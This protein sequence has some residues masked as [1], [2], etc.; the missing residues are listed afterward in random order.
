MSNALELHKHY[1]YH[2]QFY[3][4]HFFRKQVATVQSNCIIFF[5]ECFEAPCFCE[6]I[7]VHIFWQFWYTTFFCMRLLFVETF[8][9]CV[10]DHSEEA[11]TVI[12]FLRNHEPNGTSGTSLSYLQNMPIYF[13]LGKYKFSIRSSFA[14]QLF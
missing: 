12:L 2:V 8:S 4:Q 1:Q 5:R 14:T 10:H 13:S 7:H 9:A 3:V 11:Y 6:Y